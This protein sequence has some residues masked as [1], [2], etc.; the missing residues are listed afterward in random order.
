MAF[1]V[2]IIMG[3]ANIDTGKG[4]ADP[5]VLAEVFD[6]LEEFGIDT[7][8]TAHLYGASQDLLG[9][10]GA[11][12]RFTIDSKAYGGFKEGTLSNESFVKDAK[13]ALEKTGTEKVRFAK[14]SQLCTC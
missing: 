5:K 1:P 2:K 7:I 3:A 9:A 14:S 8:D 11:G 4:L 10:A 12:K 13:A 6:V